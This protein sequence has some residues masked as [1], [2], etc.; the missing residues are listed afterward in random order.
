LVIVIL[1]FILLNL[2]FLFNFLIFG[3]F[4]L[5]I[6][7]NLVETREWQWLPSVRH[8]LF[9]VIIGL[10]SWPVLRSRLGVLPKAIYLTVPVAV[11]LV[12][13]G[14]LLNSSP[15]LAYLISA[16]ITVAVIVYLYLTRRPWMYFFSVIVVAVALLIFNLTGGEI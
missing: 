11:T 7:K 12:T 3:L 8:F 13:V 16:L 5:I 4:D 14:I 9:L 10:I 15:V 2:T 1:G 6:P